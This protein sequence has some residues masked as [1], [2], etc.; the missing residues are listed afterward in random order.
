[1][2]EEGGGGRA[3]WRTGRGA[4]WVSCP[5]CESDVLRQSTTFRAD[6]REEQPTKSERE[7]ERERLFGR[8]AAS[9]VLQRESTLSLPPRSLLLL[10]PNT[11][12]QSDRATQASQSGRARQA[13]PLRPRWTILSR[14]EEGGGGTW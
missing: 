13:D 4:A 6:P 7:R 14:T 9:P 8:E 10:R 12:S 1:M 11:P 2:G 3:G 5:V